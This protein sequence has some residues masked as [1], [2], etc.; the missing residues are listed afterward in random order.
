MM[1]LYAQSSIILHQT[2]IA[3]TWTAW[4]YPISQNTACGISGHAASIRGYWEKQRR[5]KVYAVSLSSKPLHDGADV[6]VFNHVESVV[7]AAAYMI[8]L[9]NQLTGCMPSNTHHI[10]GPSLLVMLMYCMPSVMAKWAPFGNS[11]DRF[12]LTI[13]H[14]RFHIYKIEGDWKEYWKCYRKSS[15]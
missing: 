5:Q 3:G 15:Q 2:V 9:Q 4:Q 14:S 10:W 13:S 11:L 12:E 7:F 6:W 1:K 8:F